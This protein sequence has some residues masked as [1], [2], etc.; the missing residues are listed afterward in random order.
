MDNKNHQL[1]KEIGK[2]AINA[3]ISARITTLVQ[4]SNMSDKELLA[5]H[6]VGPKAV[7]ILRDY[8]KKSN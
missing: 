7:R 5:L 8:I 3:L 4:V 1:P 2:P 6:G